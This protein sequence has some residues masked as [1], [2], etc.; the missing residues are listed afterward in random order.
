[1]LDSSISDNQLEQERKTGNHKRTEKIEN[2]TTNIIVFCM[3]SGVAIIVVAGIYLAVLYCVNLWN[4]P[5]A[6]SK[7][8][9]I[10][11]H[12]VAVSGGYLA[13]FMKRHT[14]KKDKE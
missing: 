6:P 7:I 4:C 9:A 11:T 1:M 10:A 8:E 12:L 14:Q 3:W 2:Q 13:A 5:D